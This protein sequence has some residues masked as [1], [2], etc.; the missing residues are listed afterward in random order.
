MNEKISQLQP[1]QWWLVF[2]VLLLPFFYH[3]LSAGLWGWCLWL[4]LFCGVLYVVFQMFHQILSQTRKAA[5]C[6]SEGDLRVRIDIT[7]GKGHPLFYA[8]N[9]IGSDVS[10]T[11]GALGST[12]DI[13][14][15][16]AESVKK[17]S[18]TA[19]A[20]AL[21][22]RTEIAASL[23]MIQQLSES[24]NQVARFTE[25]TAESA[26]DAK[27]Q[28]QDGGQY[29]QQLES[30]LKNAS[31]QMEG[32]KSH[33]QELESESSSIGQVLETI[34]DIADQTNLLALNAA[35]EAARAGEQG[36]GFAVVADEVRTLATRTRVAT[37][38]IQKKI[39]TLLES[40]QQ[41]VEAIGKNA[42][43]M[44]ESM[45]VIGHVSQAFFRLSEKIVAITGQ[46]EQISGLLNEQVGSNERLLQGL[47]DISAV[48]EENVQVTNETLMASV[49][50]KNISGEIKSLLHRFAIDPGQ[51]AEEDQRRQ[52]LIQWGP[53]LDLNLAEINRQHQTLV[54]LVNELNHL[55]T[56]HYGLASVKRVVQGLI[57]YTANHFEYEEVLFSQFGYQDE[58][59]HVKKHQNLVKSVLEF[60]QRVERG[61][62]VGPEL[63]KFLQDWLTVHIQQEDRAYVEC[64]HQHGMK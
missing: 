14:M 37:D 29:M 53:G 12:S 45:E 60:Q 5:A 13:L 42:A 51:L 4:A 40:I 30:A 3:F 58:A 24:T 47:A 55:L 57:D 1:L 9:R 52:K 36:R 56:H 8:F 44:D 27:Q 48:S 62:Q 50:V 6:L 17:N 15:Q 28:A 23:D 2:V 64:F 63:M 41:V 21:K 54:H 11:V 10:R 43:S 31:Q 59:A 22:Q 18:E 49:A 16:V 7:E 35:I 19:E 46:S 20:G 32:S 61:E 39:E 26:V 25:S 33:I 38:D 34:S